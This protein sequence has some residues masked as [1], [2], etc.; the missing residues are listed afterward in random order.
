MLLTTPAAIRAA[1]DD[2]LPGVQKPSRYLGL[3]RN[4]TRKGWDDVAV[5][6]ALAFPD[7][8]E[9]GMSHQG[10]R[11]LYHLVNRRPDALARQDT[12]RNSGRAG[13][14]SRPRIEPE[15]DH[16]GGGSCRNHGVDRGERLSATHRPF[17]GH[18]N[19]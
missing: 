9:I 5:R 2:I 12:S 4:L 10:S 19:S 11:I 1:L 7:A 17:T 18:G 8:Y 6:V 3:E 16:A 13:T 15:A 14:S